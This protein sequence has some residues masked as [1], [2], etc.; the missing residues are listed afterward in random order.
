LLNNS[1]IG[2]LDLFSQ[3][4]R[5]GAVKKFHVWRKGQALDFAVPQ[6]P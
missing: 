3:F 2:D 6:S 5:S 1:E 4:V